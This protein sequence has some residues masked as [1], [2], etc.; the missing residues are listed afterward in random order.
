MK[1]REN[2]G[3]HIFEIRTTGMGSIDPWLYDILDT[4]HISAMGTSDIKDYLRYDGKIYSINMFDYDISTRVELWKL[5]YKTEKDNVESDIQDWIEKYCETTHGGY[6]LDDILKKWHLEIISQLEFIKDNKDVFKVSDKVFKNMCTIF[7]EMVNRNCYLPESEYDVTANEVIIMDIKAH[8][9]NVTLTIFENGF[10]FE[11]NYLD[12]ST[13]GSS[14]KEF[15][16]KN[17]LEFIEVVKK[18]W[19]TKK[20]KLD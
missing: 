8:K 19:G 12:G 5:N 18:D 20:D 9:K 17:I 7:G 3:N 6:T 13:Y 10:K 2:I 11:I 1:I 15:S 4:Y 14:L 16:Q